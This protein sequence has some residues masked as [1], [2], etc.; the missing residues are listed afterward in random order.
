MAKARHPRRLVRRPQVYAVRNPEKLNR[1][2]DPMVSRRLLRNL[3]DQRDGI[4]PRVE[5]TRQGSP[6]RG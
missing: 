2:D 5:D 3:L 1:L 6:D 4:R